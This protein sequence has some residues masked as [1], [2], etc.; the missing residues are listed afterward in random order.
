MDLVFY[1]GPAVVPSENL[2]PISLIL[3]DPT[4][5]LPSSAQRHQPRQVDK[6]LD[7]HITITRNRVYQCYL[8]R[9]KDQP[10]TKGTWMSREDL[11]QQNSD[12]LGCFQAR[13]DPYSTG[14]SSSHPVGYSDDTSSPSLW[15]GQS[16]D[17]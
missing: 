10:P 1:K 4:D 3:S 9:W 12:I 17:P 13:V 6:I 11:M 2:E 7:E 16:P 14:S 15:L 5:K 8:V